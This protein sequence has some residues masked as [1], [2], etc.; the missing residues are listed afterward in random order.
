MSAEAGFLFGGSTK[1]RCSHAHTTCWHIFLV[2]VRLTEL[3]S[4]KLARRARLWSVSA[5]KTGLS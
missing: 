5:S 1:E 2:A 3:D 4:S